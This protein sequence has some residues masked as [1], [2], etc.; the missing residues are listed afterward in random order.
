MRPPSMN[1]C[2]MM[3]PYRTPESSVWMWKTLP[4][5]RT[6]LLYPS[7]GDA[8]FVDM[9]RGGRAHTRGGSQRTTARTRRRGAD[10]RRCRGNLQLRLRLLRPRRARAHVH[11]EGPPI[12]G[13]GHE[14]ELHVTAGRVRL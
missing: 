13:D 3:C 11:L 5:W 4:L 7:R 9:S 10:R 14:L 6:L 1:R 8:N 12:P 2:V